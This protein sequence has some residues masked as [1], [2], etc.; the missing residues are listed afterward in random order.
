MQAYNGLWGLLVYVGEKD[1][2]VHK[3]TGLG[4]G[5]ATVRCGMFIEGNC[6]HPCVILRE[7]DD[8]RTGTCLT[9]MSTLKM[10]ENSEHF[11]SGQN[12]N[13]FLICQLKLWHR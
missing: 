4:G 2:A 8:R 13:Y 5:G 9:L 10:S 12:Y 7:R 6:F 11:R 1:R 3:K